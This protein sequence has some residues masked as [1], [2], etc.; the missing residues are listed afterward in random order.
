MFQTVAALAMAMPLLVCAQ[1]TKEVAP[2][3]AETK[4]PEQVQSPS[5][6]VKATIETS[7]GTI[8]L[9]LDAVKAP[10]TVANFI[11]YAK[12]SFYEG[13]IFHRVIPPSASGLPP[14]IH[15]GGL[16]ADMQQKQPDK[17]I[18]CESKNGLKNVKGTIAMARTNDPHSATAQFFINVNDNANLD[19]PS[20]DGWGYAVFGKVTK[21]M[22]V[23]EAIAAVPTITK[24]PYLNV[25][26]DAITITKVTVSQ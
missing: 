24:A 8:E 1:E 26:K 9:E 6:V 7:K 23:V 13:T 25:P 19:F 15:G 10:V 21:G 5:G 17:A 22:E 12:K 2:A 20:F 16:T 14:L 11:S 3:Q 18:Q 4:P